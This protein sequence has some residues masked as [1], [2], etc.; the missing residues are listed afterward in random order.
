MRRN[1]GG[2][3]GETV[4]DLAKPEKIATFGPGWNTDVFK[5]GGVQRADR[6]WRRFLDSLPEWER[7]VSKFLNACQHIGREADWDR[8]VTFDDPLDGAEIQW[9]P[10]RRAMDRVSTGKR[11]IEILRPGITIQQRDV[12]GRIRRKFSW[13]DPHVDTAK[14]A[15]RVAPCVAHTLDA[16][17]NALVL[18]GLHGEGETNVVAIHDSWFVP[19]I[20]V[21]VDGDCVAGSALVASCIERAGRTWLEGI[22]TV[23]GWFVDAT[24]GTPYRRFAR[25]IRRAWYRRIADQRWPTFTAS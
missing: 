19:E 12:D 18:E 22:G 20:C 13:R 21:N 14:L 9:N 6:Y 1:Y 17:F 23:Y 25:Q 4:R 2:K 8:G 5:T 16:Y 24:L 10:I 3:F 7:T 15:N 11:H